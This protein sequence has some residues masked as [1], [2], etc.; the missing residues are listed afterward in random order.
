MIKMNVYLIAYSQNEYQRRR[1]LDFIK[2]QNVNIK[3]SNGPVKDLETILQ[4]VDKVWVILPGVLNPG[5]FYCDIYKKELEAKKLNKPIEYFKINQTGRYVGLV[6]KV[7]R[8]D[9]VPHDF[10]NIRRFFESKKDI[11]KK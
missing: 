6:R 10:E 5:T 1:I 2:S 8:E 3:Y 7:E 11:F 4:D 9:L